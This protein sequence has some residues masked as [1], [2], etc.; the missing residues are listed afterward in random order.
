M[1]SAI[2]SDDATRISQKA[3]PRDARGAALG[4]RDEIVG[5]GT[6]AGE[7]GEEQNNGASEGDP[8]AVF[9]VPPERADE[10]QDKADGDGHRIGE[11]VG[12]PQGNRLGR[13][14]PVGRE[15]DEAESKD[16]RQ[17]D[18]NKEKGDPVKGHLLACIGRIRSVCRAVRPVG[19]RRGD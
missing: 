12:I 19:V 14:D 1:A 6:G 4:C 10:Q 3:P 2:A 8:L 5:G 13:Q 11:C 7:I 17:C 16:T 15:T 18:D 9:A